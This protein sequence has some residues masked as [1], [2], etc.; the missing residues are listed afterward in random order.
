MV[1]TGVSRMRQWM[2]SSLSNV[3]RATWLT[4]MRGGQCGEGRKT[5]TSEAHD[6][7]TRTHIYW[8]LRGGARR[9]Y[10]DLREYA[11]VGGGREALVARGEKRATTD[12]ATAQV[13]LARRLEQLDGLR[14]G[15]ALH[16]L[17][18]QAT[19]AGVGR[20]HLEAKAKRGK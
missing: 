10:A 18:A 20:T 14:R 3:G 17:A 1:A 4:W 13:L 6:M 12:P 9:A 2:F 15:R 7:K 11:D 8:R 19:L 16:R 5:S